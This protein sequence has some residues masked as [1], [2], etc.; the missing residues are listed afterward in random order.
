MVDPSMVR[1][2]LC[3]LYSFLGGVAMSVSLDTPTP[4]SVCKP[5]LSHQGGPGQSPPPASAQSCSSLLTACRA[6]GCYLAPAWE[7]LGCGLRCSVF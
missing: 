6:P 4:W 7:V 5:H 2:L 3:V 1:A